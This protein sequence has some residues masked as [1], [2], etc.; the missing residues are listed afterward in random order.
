MKCIYKIIA[1][2]SCFYGVAQVPTT[3]ENYIRTKTYKQPTTSAIATPNLQQATQQ[4]TYY[5]GLGRPKQQIAYGQSAT[6]KDLIIHIEYDAFGRQVKNYLPY[7]KWYGSASMGYV[8]AAQSET[9]AYYSTYSPTVTGDP[10]FEQT[11]FP[12][13]EKQLEASPLDRVLAQ[14]APGADWQVTGNHKIQFDYKTNGTNE[15]KY[16]AVTTTW[17]ASNLVYDITLVDNG[18]YYNPNELY[19]TITKDENWT[20]GNNNT[21]EEYKDKEGRVIL[22]RTYSNYGANNETYAN[23]TNVPHDT[24]YVYDNYGNLTY[25][26][27]PLVTSPTTQLDALCYQYKYD[28]RNR[29]VAKKLPGKAWEYLVYDKL[30]RVVATGPVF[31]PFPDHANTIFGWLITKY[32]AFNRPV[33]TGWQ[34]ET[35]TFNDALRGT[36]Q[37]ATNGW[38]VLNESKTTTATTIDAATVHYTNTVA[39]TTFKL[40]TV[41]YYDDYTFPNAPTTFTGT[42]VFYNN[43]TNKPKGLPTGSWVRVLEGSASN[44]YEK[45][46]I[47][48]DA[49]ARAILNKKQNYLGGY[50]QTFTKL[51]FTGKTLYTETN[52]QYNG[53][54]TTA[55]PVIRED[56]E[57]TDQDRLLKRTHK[58]G[59]GAVEL[60][61]YN[62]YN[63]LGQLT[64]KWVGGLVTAGLQK[65][66]YSYNIRGWLTGIND[67]NNLSN[68]SGIYDPQDL[69]AFKI[70]YNTVQ[71]ESNY[72]GK[73]LYNG[74]IAETYWLTASDNVTRKY[75]YFYDELNRLQEAVYQRPNMTPVVTNSYNEKLQYDKN[76]NIKTLYRNGDMDDDLIPLNIDNLSYTYNANQLSQVD[77][78]TNSPAGFKNVVGVDYAYDL[79]G[80]LTKDGNKT[81]TS[82]T[83]NH[84]NLPTKITFTGTNKYITYIYNALGQKVKKV[85]TNN[86]SINTTDYLDGFQYLKTGSTGTVK[87]QFFPTA[88]G[89]VSNTVIGTTNNY[90]YVY[91]YQDH[92]GNNRLSYSYDTAS[93][94]TKILEEN[95]YYPFGLK[96]NNYNVDK[97]YY[98]IC[99]AD[100]MNLCVKSFTSLPYKYKY[101]GKELQDELGLSVYDY[102]ARFYDPALGRWGTFDPKAEISRRWSPYRYAYDNPLRFIDPD[103]MLEN[104]YLLDEKDNV[105]AVIFN[106][107]ADR[108]FRE[109]DKSNVSKEFK[110]SNGNVKYGEEIK[111]PDFAI[112]QVFT[113]I[114]GSIGHAALGFDGNVFNYYPTN[115]DGSIDSFGGSS[116]VNSEL[117]QVTRTITNFNEHYPLSNDFFIKTSIQEKENLSTDI[118]NRGSFL[119]KSDEKY[120]LFSNNCTTNVVNHLNSAKIF[121]GLD[122]MRPGTLDSNLKENPRVNNKII[123]ESSILK[124]IKERQNFK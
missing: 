63:E 85:V 78:S 11:A 71:N 55:L 84:L 124:T 19:K 72:T 113:E 38:T 18:T 106:D 60:M 79:F 62:T 101:N 34:Q 112:I 87:L 123:R 46:Y 48:Y 21:V 116:I 93:S 97:E 96:H 44:N 24:Y 20:A 61:N 121:D 88:E 95:N 64:S 8:S 74:N 67:I 118:T 91:N 92:L 40:L 45:S 89:Y 23:T 42:D 50:T 66:D 122:N 65:V 41:N 30:D 104:D 75:G 10:R 37:S 59:T 70:N 3:S 33:Y 73:P 13:S 25:V 1:L 99:F 29:L 32:D 102:G 108:Y 110:L 69:F 28:S 51:D 83:Y 77:D 15:V 16:Y 4:V 109:S 86:T 17:N 12:F 5:D 94:T 53:T 9:M 54:A 49:K 80:N 114:E 119:K 120:S 36:R 58:I 56:F 6:G 82:I 35:G 31:S 57:Y 7:A 22:K 47:L 115:S 2:F 14:G 111:N 39:P 103:G 43:T 76:G 105:K 98:D 81:I 107:K 27:P 52:H 68:N 90:K 26:L 117:Q 100:P